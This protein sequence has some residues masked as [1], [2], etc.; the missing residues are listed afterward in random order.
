MELLARQPLAVGHRKLTRSLALEAVLIS[1]YSPQSWDLL[2][3]A[4]TAAD[5][6]EGLALLQISDASLGRHSDGSY[7]NYQEVNAAIFCLDNAVPSD[8][9]S[10]DQLGP[11]L[12]NLSALFGP[13]LQYNGIGCSYWPV[14][15]SRT[16]GPLAADGAPPI[17]LIGGTGDPATPYASAEAVNKEIAGSFL[18]TRQGYGH[19]SYFQSACVREATDAYLIDLV[20]PPPGTV[21]QSD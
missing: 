3:T 1:L 17:L 8:I 19:G 13:A 12:S 18:L 4:L 7:S 15:P 21:C 2:Q 16:A 6:G 11:T 10:Y 5:Q 20:L 14:K 9:A